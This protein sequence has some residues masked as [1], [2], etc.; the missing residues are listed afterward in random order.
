MCFSN[1]RGSTSWKRRYSSCSSRSCPSMLPATCPQRQTSWTP[2]MA[3]QRAQLPVHQTCP[4]ELQT[5]LPTPASPHLMLE[6]ASPLS[7]KKEVR[8]MRYLQLRACIGP[9]CVTEHSCSLS[10]D[11]SLIRQ[12]RTITLILNRY[13]HC[14]GGCALTWSSR[15]CFSKNILLKT[16]SEG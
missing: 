7:K 10:G 1:N 12:L 9:V 14:A 13:Q 11:T 2:P 4:L 3:G 16:V 15:I 5:I 6:A 8:L